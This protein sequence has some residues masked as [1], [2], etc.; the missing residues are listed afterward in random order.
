[1]EKTLVIPEAVKIS[2]KYRAG[3]FDPD[4]IIEVAKQIFAE[5]GCSFSC[6]IESLNKQIAELSSHEA[7]NREY[8]FKANVRLVLI[9]SKV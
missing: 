9:E 6:A 4:R 1:M 5:N 8:D 2:I 7:L 3:S